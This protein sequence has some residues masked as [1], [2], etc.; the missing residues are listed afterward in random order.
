MAKTLRLHSGSGNQEGWGTANKLNAAEIDQI[1]DPQ[2]GRAASVAVSI[3]SP[4]ARMHLVETAFQFVETAEKKRAPADSVYHQLLGHYWD[5]WELVFNYFQQRQA[6]QRLSIRLWNRDAELK[7]LDGG[8]ERHRELAKV[9]RLFGQDPRFREAAE[10]HLLYFPGPD[11]QPRLIGGTSPLTL[12]FPAPN[13]KPLA[14]ARPQGSGHYFDNLYVPLTAR[15]PAFQEYVCQLFTA[16]VA[17]G[18]TSL[19]T[20]AP[21]V[22]A[23]LETTLRERVLQ[24]ATDISQYPVLTA[25]NNPVVVAGVPVRVRPDEATVRT[26]DLKIKPTRADAPQP[27]PLVLRPGQKEPTRKYYNQTA[28]GESGARVPVRDPR[29]LTDRTLPGPEWAYPYLTVDDLLTETLLAVPYAVD[30]ERFY[31]GNVTIARDANQKFWPL[32]PLRPEYFHYFTPDDLETQLS[33]DVSVAG[34]RVKLR[35]PVSGGGT[36]DYERTYVENPQADG[37]G[38]LR[39]TNVGLAFFPLLR[40]TGENAARYNDYYKVMLVDANVGDPTIAGRDKTV[41]LRFFTGT[42]ALTPHGTEQ[43]ARR[44]DRTPKERGKEGSAYYEIRG[45]SFD[46]LEIENPDPATGHA[47]VV[48]RWIERPHG[49]KEFRFAVDFGTTNTHVAYHTAPNEPPQP[50]AFGPDDPPVVLLK[51]ATDEPDRGLYERMFRGIDEDGFVYIRRWQLYQQ[52]EFVPPLLGHRDSPYQFP[53]RTATSQS[54]VFDNETPNLLD[55]VNIGFGLN[56]EEDDAGYHTNLKWEGGG[57]G[58]AADAGRARVQAFLREL[59]LLFRFKAAMNGGKLDATRI[60]WFAPLSFPAYELTRYQNSWDALSREVFH[61]QAPTTY[62]PESTAPFYFLTRRGIIAPGPGE[63][64]AFVDVGGGTTDILVYA[65]RRPVLSTSFRFAGNDLWG[66]GAAEVGGAQDNGLVRYG[67]EAFEAAPRPAGERAA[68]AE[69][70]LNVI[71]NSRRDRR[72]GSEEL[73][74]LLFSYDDVFR[75]SDRILDA[76][77]LRV[78]LYLHF[79]AIVYHV[80]QL[81]ALRGHQPPRYLCF[82]GRGSLYVR[83]LAGGANLAPV[84]AVARLILARVLGADAPAN[85]KIVLADDPKQTTAN[86]GVLAA[87]ADAADV[88]NPPKLLAVGTGAATPADELRDLE[89][90]KARLLTVPAITESLKAAV[91]ANVG[92]CLD[93]LLATPDLARLQENLGVKNPPGH[94][95]ALLTDSLLADSFNMGLTNYTATLPKEDPHIPETLFFLGLKNALYELSKALY[96]GHSH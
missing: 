45:T 76:R 74:S 71:R 16:P 78:V 82:T 95:R 26:S 65:D 38:R 66:D 9:L 12:F 15:E 87:V 52:R 69:K 37:Y 75:F 96:V 59:L 46:F 77:H 18:E 53:I 20:L 72:A 11:G 44:Y 89:L 64:A 8:S 22:R 61:H 41:K 30:R 29:P 7:K 31:C 55:N 23:A 17:P 62:L 32:L 57:T 42:R 79:G 92:V 51:R 5:L 3:P 91:L 85:F 80:G 94:V 86:G 13:L 10:L 34:V 40:L 81:M 49:S 90:D 33:L 43:S 48:P 68:L 24:G 1:L 88:P 60:V 27:L 73:A 2:G 84:E 28:F 50:F 54:A 19:G 6:A 58:P 56:T 83:L 63:A 21:V 4:F 67:I 35:L 36:V 39:V 93:L 25:A 14:L 47:L 70:N